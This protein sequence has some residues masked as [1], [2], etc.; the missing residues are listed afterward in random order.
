MTIKTKRNASL[1]NSSSLFVLGTASVLLGSGP[2]QAFDANSLPTGGNVTGGSATIATSG[3]TLTVNQSSNRAII[4]WRNFDIGAN[5][6][7]NFVQPGTSSI[8]VNRVNGSTDPSRIDGGLHANGQVWVLNPNGVF[9]GKTARVDA[10][11]VVA[12]TANINDK[13]FMAGSNKLQMTGGDNGQVVNE[14]HISVGEGGLAAFV[15][16]SVRNSGT[17]RARLGKVTL[18]AGDTYT[19]D[20][21]G[22]RLVEIGL[23]SNKAVVDQSGKIVNAGG[24]IEISAKAAGQVVDAVINTS[25]VTDASS[26]RSVGGKI[27]LGAD[28]IN[29]AADASIKAD[30]TSGGQITAIANKTGNYA[31][32]W[33]AQGTTGDGGQIETSGKTV[34][35]DNNI[36]VNTKSA[37]GKTGNWTLDPD[38][39]T[40]QAGSGGDVSDT[41]QSTVGADTV[42]AALNT[43]DVTLQ[44]NHSITV[45][46][47]INAAGNANAHSLALND[48]DGGG[49]T[50]NLNAAITLKSGGTLSG[51]GTT[52]N[53]A[54][55]LAQNGIDVATSGATVNLAAATYNEA[56][57]IT[58]SGLT[59]D[60]H[61]A[62]ISPTTLLNTGV[63]HKY[64][65]SVKTA[66]F[67]HDATG[68]T[69]NDLNIDSGTLGANATVFWNNASGSINHSSISSRTPLNGGQTGQGLAVDATGGNTATL[70]V[71][72]VNFSGF[73]K[74]AIDAVNGDGAT[75]GGGNIALTVQG[76]TI[77]GA[78]NT[79]TIAQNGI[80]VWERAGG[81]VD[82]TVDNDHFSNLSF[83]DP[84]TATAA[85]VIVYGVHNG[86]VTVSNSDFTNVQE[87]ISTADSL[88]GVDAT[89][90]NTF[91]TVAAD[92]AT[93]DQLFAIENHMNH[94]TEDASAGLVRVKAGQVYATAIKNDLS[95]AIAAASAGDTV[96]VQDGT[97]TVPSGGSNYLNITKA[98][99]LQ[100]QSEAHTIIDASNAST[101]GLRVQADNVTLSNFTLNGPTST[102]G[103]GIK[104]E[105]LE[106]IILPTD[107][108]NHFNIDSVTETGSYKNG[109]DLNGVASGTI[110]NVTVSGTTHGTGIAITDSANLTLTHNTTTGNAWGGLALYQH[111]ATYNQ[112]VDGITVD[113]T[114]H[115]NEANGVYME[116]ESASQDFGSVTIAGY[117][118]A[119]K[120]TV[121]PNDSY[122]WLQNGEQAAIDFALTNAPTVAS[123]QGW[124]GSAGNNIF[125][126]GYNTG[127]TQAL[128]INA[129][130]NA[131]VAGGTINVNAGTYREQVS[132]TKDLTLAGA[133]PSAT[134]IESPD[135]LA[136]SFTSGG[137]TRKAV[138]SVDGA[139]VTIRDLGIDGRG[140]GNANNAFVGLALHNAGG[141]LADLK[142]T[143]IRDGGVGGS[144][145]GA[146]HGYG[147][148]A[149][150]DDG[151]SRQVVLESSNIS[152]F[153][154]AGAV[155]SGAGLT[156]NVSGNTITGA[157]STA[158][159]A[160]NG[161]EFLGATGSITGNTISG[162]GYSPDT[163]WAT[164][165]Y[166]DGAAG[167]TVSGNTVA[168]AG[169]IAG[170]TLGLYAGNSDGLRVSNNSF[171][172]VEE[173]IDLASA[174]AV[175]S[176]NRFLNSANGIEI[177][178]SSTGANIS[179]N[180]F[181]NNLVHVIGSD[182]SAVPGLLADNT[183]DKTVVATGGANIYGDVNTAINNEAAG[184]T[185]NL[186]ANHFGSGIVVS[187]DGDTLVGTNGTVIDALNNGDNGITIA[188]NNV[189]VTGLEIAGP[190]T[191][192]YDTYAW[193]SDI[194]RGIVVNRGVQNFAIT[195]NNIHG[196]RN[197]ILVNGIDNTGSITGNTIADSKSGISVQYTDGAGIDIEGNTDGG[198][199]NEWGVNL[200]LN[201][202]Y[203]AS[204]DTF[205]SNSQKIA[206]DADAVVQGQIL[207]TSI[208][209][210]GWT[211]QDQ[212]YTNSN[213]SAVTVATTGNDA[214]QGSGLNSL[215][216]IQAGI[217]AVING[218]TV[219]VKAGTY[220]QALD[221][222][223]AL[224][225][226]GAG[227]GQT[228]IKPTTLL[229][230]HT[231]HK[232]DADVKT[233][234]FVNGVG[235]VNISGVTIDS[236]NP[237]TN[238]TVFWNNAGG[239]IRNSEIANSAAPSGPQ[240]GQGIAVDAADGF[241][242]NLTID[243]VSFHDWSKN[244]IDAVTGNGA[245]SLGG[246]IN[247]TVTGSTF[248]G[249]GDIGTT[250]QNGIVLWERGGGSVSATIDN[251]TF[252]D[253]GYTDPSNT[254]AGVLVYGV[255]NGTVK[256]SN[257]T[258]TN[259]QEY[260]STADSVNEVDATTG[261]TFD[262]VAADT[263]TLDQLF[264]IE[265]HM[266]HATE[267]ATTS[268]VRV[269]A[270]N[271]YVTADKADIVDSLQVASA[272][273]T[274][275]IQDGTYVVP[276]GGGNYLDITKAVTLK[277]QSQAGTIIDASNASTYGLRVQADDVSLSDF[278]LKGPTAAGGYGIKVEPLE[279][280]ITPA[281]RVHNFSIANV[282]E[283]GSYKNGLDL[284][285]VIGATISNV[286]VSGT[287]HGTG[288]A[289]TDSADVTLTGNTTTGNAWGG[290][291]LYQHNA[292][293]DQQV[294]NITV[295]GT[296][297]FG[298]ANGVYMEDESASKD[299]GFVTV[300][301]YDHAVKAT[302]ATN[303]SY[304]WL[305]NGVQTAID[306]AAVNAPTTASVQGWTGSGGDN[307][308]SVGVGANGTA[309]SVN[310]ALDQSA[311]G[312]IIDVLNGTYAESVAI[313]APRTVNF[314]GATL[315]SL[316]V[317][318]GGS[319]ST[320]S[321]SVK[322]GSVT[323]VGDIALGGDL[324]LDTS[325]AKGTIALANVD[326][327]HDL[328]LNAGSTG[329]VLVGGLGATT[330][331][332]AVDITAD[333]IG[334]GATNKAASFDFNGDVALSAASTV[335]D[336]TVSSTAAGDITFAGDAD[337]GSGHGRQ[338][339]QW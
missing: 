48:Q 220:D 23:G 43:T 178:A 327:A 199:A 249:A 302:V 218:G 174:N 336:T 322:A 266:S 330:R 8:A 25:G 166:L 51:Q 17:I 131:A 209:N 142:I 107:R 22:D 187:Q 316:S 122:T 286:T 154:K 56:L 84:N 194:T 196:T 186:S 140:Q 176:G 251:S 135:V 216:T 305:Q 66:L 89:V 215:A 44:A 193:G 312:G 200:H 296:N 290:L 263:A 121:A 247:L 337:G 334:L 64:D 202:H 238:A 67:V 102:G 11:G 53:V 143:G 94:G 217:N 145:D 325:A 3:N 21:A 283:T 5:A 248:T 146:Q 164:A 147:V 326:G 273:D 151:V 119:V 68:V 173:G 12:T 38:D 9:F 168:G 29:V 311:T 7:A 103:Y 288:I 26:V 314:D 65:A 229:D 14:G 163:V 27:V 4:D 274:V 284:N 181:T 179:G 240:T 190:A 214:N 96:N 335:I 333:L 180:T 227:A 109:L 101:Y 30:G 75:T 245:T 49:L 278:T 201:G 167:A 120:A 18:A 212:G 41:S 31:G 270:G 100:G 183:F 86:T 225:L 175:L 118:H 315:D 191:S 222:E 88:N 291:A 243:N 331:L 303:D 321:G 300:N 232:Y 319:G 150:N 171:D 281:D 111:N 156:A 237:G 256:V 153:Q 62:S 81:T 160:Q 106:N 172:G 58:T 207:A 280:V 15:A 185:L 115:F 269:K 276:S 272:G 83:N 161:I 2:A 198:N 104:V 323:A 338:V 244:A 59:L 170:S 55:G 282:T 277:G 254:A 324:T 182:A 279:L 127:H 97:Y 188:A 134:T 1:L 138:V 301:G 82:L 292:T 298:E 252:S 39:L 139:N 162:I 275:N 152:D 95:D 206:T 239:S 36:A 177:E 293:Y 267:D 299:F 47:A 304:T 16:P 268:L 213:R 308:F 271:V 221:I 219:N 261:N 236:N 79:P 123:V 114:N 211:V 117:D 159:I 287:T 210:N 250:A 98:L 165:I 253:L 241:V 158:L 320:L 289:I 85:G 46:S 60:G 113:G 69:L 149:F 33:S 313:I 125:A 157:G 110:S 108:V 255:H 73:N 80:L 228:I 42:V 306:F 329:V 204:T 116:D 78:D 13:A 264:A 297:S 91:D 133:S 19:L 71:D 20:L 332:G 128:S 258:F 224:N 6:Q 230:T 77:V 61:G 28:V 54:G 189:T 99:T 141:V 309:L 32:S 144:L 328:T 87:Y 184:S 231:A 70:L 72:T 223:K 93:L 137:T 105:P 197:N 257:S 148:A 233:A 45:N 92:T 132:I 35:I 203:D 63:G 318:A 205:F 76:S 90:G 192:S 246:D 136:A 259:V 155:F 310:E 50:I 235:D 262:G 295:D 37:K 307:H 169:G 294:N 285:G 242:S 124:N 260:I 126:V 208:L 226:T 34:H 130:V 57:S 234:V 24:V 74:N 40:V 129:A 195:D 112:Q 317:F 265:D 10:A 52:V 339:G